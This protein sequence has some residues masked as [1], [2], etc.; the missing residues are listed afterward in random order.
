MEKV[1]NG[2]IS[3]STPSEA[4]EINLVKADLTYKKADAEK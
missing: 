4:A 1:E 3:A 2:E